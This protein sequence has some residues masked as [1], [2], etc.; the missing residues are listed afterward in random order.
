MA[1]HSL[2]LSGLVA[3]DIMVFV[4]PETWGHCP[5]TGP[6]STSSSKQLGLAFL[7][8]L[9]AHIV[10]L[11]EYAVAAY[12]LCYVASKPQSLSQ[13]N[14]DSSDPDTTSHGFSRPCGLVAFFSSDRQHYLNVCLFL[15]CSLQPAYTVA[16]MAYGSLSNIHADDCL[17]GTVR[18]AW[19]QSWLWLFNT[20][21]FLFLHL[22]ILLGILGV[23]F[24]GVFVF[25]ECFNIYTACCTWKSSS[26]AELTA[27]RQELDLQVSAI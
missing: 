20:A 27:G 8:V 12:T 13:P 16:D 22:V 23:A 9:A 7:K 19:F 25:R 4:I 6:S 14:A 15:I 10:Q 21:G 11:G 26:E 5:T 17:H 3:V 24:L 18:L 1:L 2:K